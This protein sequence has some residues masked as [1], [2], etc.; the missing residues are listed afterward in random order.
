M[1]KRNDAPRSFQIDTVEKPSSF[2][3]DTVERECRIEAANR[4]QHEAWTVELIGHARAAGVPW[5]TVAGWLGLS[6]ST[7]IRMHRVP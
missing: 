1:S 5:D 2:Q 6:R 7:V 3:I 4:A